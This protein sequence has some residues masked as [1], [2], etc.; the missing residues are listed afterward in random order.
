[1]LPEECGSS[2][3]QGGEHCRLFSGLTPGHPHP[4]SARLYPNLLVWLWAS[5]IGLGSPCWPPAAAA[6]L[7]QSPSI[8]VYDSLRRYPYFFALSGALTW[9]GEIASTELKARVPRAL[10]TSCLGQQHLPLGWALQLG[11]AAHLPPSMA[12]QCILCYPSTHPE[13]H[14]MYEDPENF[15]DCLCSLYS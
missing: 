9:N 4:C 8:S 7:Q 1:M 15:K 6:F 5:F 14:R 2:A 10:K 12:A 3:P 13:G 11:V